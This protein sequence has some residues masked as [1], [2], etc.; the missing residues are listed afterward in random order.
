M[1]NVEFRAALFSDSTEKAK[2]E[3]RS[4]IKSQMYAALCEII[5]G[6]DEDQAVK[7]DYENGKVRYATSLAGQINNWH[8]RYKMEVVKLKDTGRGLLA[9]EMGE[10]SEIKNYYGVYILKHMIESLRV[11][12]LTDQ[13]VAK[14]P[15]FE[16]LHGWWQEMPNYN[17][18]AV[19]NSVPGQ[20]HSSR[21][22]ELFE[23]S[24][25]KKTE[26]EDIRLC[27]TV[28]SPEKASVSVD[29]S[30]DEGDSVEKLTQNF[31][32]MSSPTHKSKNI[33]ILYS[34]SLASPSLDFDIHPM[35]MPISTKTKP[36]NSLDLLKDF[37][38]WDINKQ[39]IAKGSSAKPPLMTCKDPAA[40]LAAACSEEAALAHRWLETS[41]AEKVLLLDGR[42]T[43]RKHHYEGAAEEHRLMENCEKRQHDLEMKHLEIE[44]MKLQLQLAQACQS[45]PAGP[46]YT[47]QMD[48]LGSASTLGPPLLPVFH[49]HMLALGA[50]SPFTE[51][52]SFSS[53]GPGE[54]S[55]GGVPDSS[56]RMGT[57]GDMDYGMDYTS[58]LHAQFGA[59]G[60][61]M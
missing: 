56:E 30:D 17:P 18:I 36:E 3:N 53:S 34:P 50:S 1:D 31:S 38:G 61:H 6:N 39:K 33:S 8:S 43:K 57:L 59:E 51:S 13:I 52:G 42:A 60:A 2:E 47:P 26:T 27:R 7:E 4:K 19:T 58:E 12:L 45:A 49:P 35:R 41:H 24:D 28:P 15:L 9:E 32:E 11:T 44:Q 14:W 29:T 40:V 22:Q 23:V 46:S 48:H 55:Q 10:D 20:D 54:Y 21:A 16:T 25:T 5:F 37:R